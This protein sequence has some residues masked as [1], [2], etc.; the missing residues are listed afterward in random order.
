M[1][2]GKIHY[3]HTLESCSPNYP[4]DV[5]SV[6]M[7]TASDYYYKNGNYKWVNAN[8]LF[9][10]DLYLS[11]RNR[12]YF[13]V[14]RQGDVYYG[15]GSEVSEEILDYSIK[16]NQEKI[17]GYECDMLYLSSKQ[18]KDNSIVHRYIYFTDEIKIDSNAFSQLKYLSHDFIQS[19]IHS[20]PLKIVMENP[21]FSITWEAESVEFQSLSDSI[22]Y[23][24][25]MEEAMPVNRLSF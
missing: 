11:D 2:E 23:M 6:T 12:N 20:I 18:K 10:E 3:R 7:D 19:K 24:P 4:L 9:R 13:L 5:L 22:F 17:L 25:G 8:A 16:R 21:E 15:E 14:G 1:F